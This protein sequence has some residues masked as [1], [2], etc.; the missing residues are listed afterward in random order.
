M[1]PAIYSGR[2]QVE[3]I[4]EEDKDPYEEKKQHFMDLPLKLKL[5]FLDTYGN[6]LGLNYNDGLDKLYKCFKLGN[7]LISVNY[8]DGE[9]HSI[10]IEKTGSE[11]FA[12]LVKEYLRIDLEPN[13]K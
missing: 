6:A 8:F 3:L 5:F 4:M 10:R 11:A 13:K 2:N 1:H 9:Y 12:L 7:P